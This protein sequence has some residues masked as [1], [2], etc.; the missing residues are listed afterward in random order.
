MSAPILSVGLN[1]AAGRMGQMLARLIVHADDFELVLALEAPGHA[2]V[3]RDIGL[4]AGV[5]EAGVTIVERLGDAV[6]DVMI[7]FSGPEA[8]ALCARWCAHHKVPMVI[9]TTGLAD[10]NLDAV[11]SASGSVPVVLAPNMSVGVNELLDL[12]ARAAA[13]LG[14]EYDVE[15]VETHHRFKKDAPSGTA[16]ALAQRV[17]EVLDRDISRDLVHGREGQVGARSQREIGVHAVRAGDVVGDHVVTFATLGERIELTHR[18]HT[19]ETF[20][21]GALRAA[22]FVVDQSPGLYTMA[23]VLGL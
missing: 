17:A 13:M 1:G 16:L 6:P 4:I 5:G 14:P 8:A 18:A 20:A 22:K 19:R 12:V 10:K 11:V 3:G 15:I 2:E 23:D 7:D 21:R 9:G